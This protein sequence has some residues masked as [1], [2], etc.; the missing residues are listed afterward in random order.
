MWCKPPACIFVREENYQLRVI[1]EQQGQ[2]FCG[3]EELT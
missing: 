3:L 2:R 1:L